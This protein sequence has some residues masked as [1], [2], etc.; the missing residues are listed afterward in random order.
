MELKKYQHIRRVFFKNSSNML[1]AGMQY[2][3]SFFLEIVVELGYIF[4]YLLFYNIIYSQ[5]SSIGGW[6]YYQMLIL[7]GMSIITTELMYAFI[8]TFNIWRLPERIQN[9]DVD[10][11][12][13]KPI[14]TLYTL[15][16]SNIYWTSLFSSVT[17]LGLILV[18]QTH[19]HLQISLLTLISSLIIYGAG[20]IIIYCLFT[21]FASLTFVFL[22]ADA[23]PNL[24]DHLITDNLGRPHQMYAGALR[25]FF[26]YFFPIVFAS[27]IPATNL[28]HGFSLNYTVSSVIIALIF[29]RITKLV[30]QKMLLRYSSASS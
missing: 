17:G 3:F 11:A 26:F 7:A 16:A 10:Y 21:I 25:V 12:L 22:N 18:A 6:N 30:W 5:I 19:L 23:L 13:L 14:S 24:I 15:T 4:V 28:I 1:Q 2:R 9:G 29:M 20:L 27:S 8:L